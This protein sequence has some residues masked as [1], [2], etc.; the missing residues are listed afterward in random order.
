M[1][2]QYIASLCLPL[3]LLSASNAFANVSMYNSLSF[4]V[5]LLRSFGAGPLRYEG[6]NGLA[7]IWIFL[8][9]Q[10]RSEFGSIASLH[11]CLRLR[12]I[13]NMP[14]PVSR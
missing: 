14:R 10:T 13:G 1:N 2:R 6:D 3:S 11:K 5:S 8:S 12:S 7:I 9:M 4:V